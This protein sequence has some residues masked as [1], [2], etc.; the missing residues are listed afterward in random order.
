MLAHSP[1]LPLVIDYPDEYRDIAAKDEEGAILALKQRDRVRRV[2]LRMPIPNLQKLV[3]AIDEEYPI[4]EYLV[5][6]PSLENSNPIVKFP[7]TLRAPHLRHLLLLAFALPVGSRLLTTAV[8]LVTLSIF[9]AHPSTYFHPN[10]LLQWFSLMP[11]LE[12]LMIAFLLPVP[13]R[14]VERQLTHTPITA[15]ITL[16]NLRLF[17]FRGVSAYLEA[18]VHRI[19]TPRRET[20]D[21]GFFNQLTFSAPRLLQS[22]SIAEN[23]LR[24]ESAKFEFSDDRLDVE[25]YPRVEAETYALSITVDCR[26]LDWQVSS[27]AQIS[28]SLSQLFSAVERLCVNKG[29]ARNERVRVTA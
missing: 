5:I 16:P 17:R 13:S 6:I 4:L 21:I 15:P 1:P 12:T 29:S 23:N 7:E 27:A 19:T 20:L 22:M 26:D 2:R 24:F 25:F 3:A 14:V 10:T 28:N 11:Q 18:L 9:M 8:S